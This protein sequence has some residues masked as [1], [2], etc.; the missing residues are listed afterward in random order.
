V[1]NALGFAALD[2]FGAVEAAA[3][4]N[5]IV[6]TVIPYLNLTTRLNVR[7]VQPAGSYLSCGT[8]YANGPAD[9]M[10]DDTSITNAT[11]WNMRS[12]RPTAHG[13]PDD[14]FEY[15]PE[16]NWVP[17]SPTALYTL[18]MIDPVFLVNQTHAWGP[19]VQHWMII[20]IPGNDTAKGELVNPLLGPGP[21]EVNMFHKYTFVLYRQSGPLTLTPTERSAITNRTNFV[22]P[23]FLATH[24]LTGAAGVNWGYSMVDPWALV[25]LDAL[26]FQ[27]LDC[28]AAVQT[29]ASYLGIVPV[30]IPALDLNTQLRVSYNQPAGSY[31][32]CG[33]TYNEVAFNKSLSDTDVKLVYLQPWDLRS[34]RPGQNA[35][36]DVTSY[37][38]DITWTAATGLHIYSLLVVDPVYLFNPMDPSGPFVNHYM[39]ININNTDLKTGTVINPY[40]GPAP[41]DSLYHKYLFL[42]YR[43]SGLINLTSA[44]INKFQTRRN[45]S[46]PEFVSAHNLGNP[47]GA[48]WAFAQADLWSPVA[49][50]YIGF[51]PLKCPL[52]PTPA[53]ADPW[54]HVSTGA[55][56]AIL[57]IGGLVILILLALVLYQRSA[58]KRK[59]GSDYNKLAGE[60]R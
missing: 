18:M 56:T 49:Q 40:F 34:Y 33:Q 19:Y 23:L 51:K 38:P 53:A 59:V 7:Y 29:A 14:L 4:K 32:N 57:I 9:F 10:L 21:S 44:Q 28:F 15:Q 26:G 41:L 39:V 58:N 22:L 2:C 1:Q 17:E 42:L 3:K 35:T 46:L 5:G 31:I 50:S 48:N 8:Q 52:S 45:F 30:I 27:T 25:Q 20:N 6:P 43:Q 12:Y 11:P 47:V 16:V 60:G 36:K 54:V 55:F 13:F 37:T 24:N